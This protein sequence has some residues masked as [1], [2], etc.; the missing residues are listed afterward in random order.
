MTELVG[1]ELLSTLPFVRF[2]MS[3]RLG[4]VSP[5]PLGMNLSYH[6][7][8]APERVA[9]NREKFF[10]AVG[11]DPLQLALPR[12]CH[13]AKV[14][15]A[16]T[17]GDYQ[18]CDGLTTATAGVW[19]AV[20]IA[21]CVPVIL[22]DAQRKA[23]AALHAGW[24][25][26]VQQI[27]RQGIVLMS[28]AFGTKSEG[29]IAYIGPSAGAC[30]Y[31]V[32]SDVAEQFPPTA[33]AKRNGSLFLNLKLENKRQ[34]QEAGVP[35]NNIETSPYCTICKSDLF[36][37]YRRDKERSGRMMAVVGIRS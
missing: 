33:F 22:A 8:D 12:Q 9:A 19:L 25:G 14:V 15:C 29:L 1:S 13:S 20:S 4:G 28:E 26:T 7:G 11:M 16:N 34:L 24:R 23:V 37:S 30:C 10:H 3:T 5:E 27:V 32:G 35:E 21:D 6:V 36:H 2:A 31:E 17:G 18:A